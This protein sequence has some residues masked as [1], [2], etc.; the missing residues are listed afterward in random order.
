MSNNLFYALPRLSRPNQIRSAKKIFEHAFLNEENRK[1]N[2]DGSNKIRLAKKRLE[3]AMPMETRKRKRN[4]INFKYLFNNPRAPFKTPG[5][6]HTINK[7][8]LHNLQLLK[9][10]MPDEFKKAKKK[11]EN[12]L[13]DFSKMRI[14]PSKQLYRPVNYMN[15]TIK[16]QAL[17]LFD[18]KRLPPNISKRL[19]GVTSYSGKHFPSNSRRKFYDSILNTDVVSQKRNVTRNIKDATSTKFREKQARFI[20]GN[21]LFNPNNMVTLETLLAAGPAPR[22]RG[23]RGAVLKYQKEIDS[24]L[25]ELRDYEEVVKTNLNLIMQKKITRVTDVHYHRRINMLK[26]LENDFVTNKLKLFTKYK[27]IQANIQKTVDSAF[28]QNYESRYAHTYFHTKYYIRKT[29]PKVAVIFNEMYSLFVTNMI[30]PTVHHDFYQGYSQENKN[31]IKK[32]R[33]F[34]D[35]SEIPEDIL[36]TIFKKEFNFLKLNATPSNSNQQIVYFS[37]SNS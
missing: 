8:L 14:Y 13:D 19:L 3:N 9:K 35:F 12:E 33:K 23:Y 2:L 24:L 34:R 20:L 32:F 21:Q 17:K 4:L 36:N 7:N 25:T 1:K 30:H 31:I 15:N 22:N 28:N 26:K 27:Q 11:F 16:A 37:N 18:N 10:W 6:N 29:D 5:N